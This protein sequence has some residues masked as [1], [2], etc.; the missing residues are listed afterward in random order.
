MC[1]G[2]CSDITAVVVGC[3]DK[4]LALI[5]GAGRFRNVNRVV[6][7][8]K[9]GEKFWPSRRAKEKRRAR[10]WMNRAG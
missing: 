4:S 3:L 2:S 9:A 8:G 6:Y 1:K 10:E 7:S 5:V